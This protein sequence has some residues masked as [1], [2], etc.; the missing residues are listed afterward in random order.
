MVEWTSTGEAGQTNRPRD[1]F[2]TRGSLEDRREKL[3]QDLTYMWRSKLY[4]DVRIHLDFSATADSCSSDSE[5]STLSLSSTA[6][7]AAHRCILATR[8]PYFASLFLNSSSFQGQGPDIALPCP[9]FTPAALHFCLGYMYAG[10]LDFSNR[11][12]DLRTAFAIHRAA[13]Y[14][15]MKSLVAEIESRI[16]HDF[17]HGFDIGKIHCRYC[18]L[19]AARVWSFAVSSDAG[20]S[21]LGKHARDYIKVRWAESWGMEIATVDDAERLSLLEQVLESIRS[22]HILA[23]FKSLIA[24]RARMERLI[25]DKGRANLT[26]IDSLESMVAAIENH[27]NSL[28]LKHFGELAVE[29]EFV[30]ICSGQKL[31]VEVVESLFDALTMACDAAKTYSSGPIIYQILISK[32][33]LRTKPDSSL[34]KL[35]PRSLVRQRAESMLRAIEGSIRRRWTQLQSIGAFDE[36]DSWVLNELSSGKWAVVLQH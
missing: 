12:F 31:G 30:D 16:E 27:A 15:Q 25:R 11:N 1:P 17:C 10:R 24:L 19:R 6:I 29:T 4:V 8:S 9:P 5:S 20:A 3:G 33:L 18:P 2:G 22:E 35:P 34:V 21:D 28:L 23:T 36:L 7:F 13:T 26:W 32:V 14:L